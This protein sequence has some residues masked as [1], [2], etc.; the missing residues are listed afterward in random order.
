MGTLRIISVD[1]KIA[2]V[3]SWTRVSRRGAI[4]SFGR[5]AIAD[6][7]RLHLRPRSKVLVPAFCCPSLV[8]AHT[9]VQCQ[10]VWF[11]LDDVLRMITER[12]VF[13][14]LRRLDGIIPIAY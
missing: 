3:G 11:D 10:P 7:L 8:R 9:H 13:S 1:P 4:Y 12:F 5:Y 6:A 2:P 14:P